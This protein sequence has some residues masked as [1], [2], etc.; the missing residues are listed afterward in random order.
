[1]KI[2]FWT[3]NM[4]Y[5]NLNLLEKLKIIKSL[6][7]FDWVEIACTWHWYKFSNEELDLLKTFNTNTFHL[8]FFDKNEIDFCNYII[9]NI[10]NF[11]HFV[12]HPD[13]IILNDIPQYLHKYISIENMD[14][15]KKSHKFPNEIENLFKNY[16]NLNFTFD[17]NHCDE[18]K[19]KRQE[20]LDIKIPK[21][22]HFSTVNN[23][24]YPNN[25][26]IETPH[27]LAHLDKN[28]KINENYS[29]KKIIVTLEWVVVKNDIESIKKEYHF[30]KKILQNNI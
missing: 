30:C 11:S 28:F 17:I 7:L 18:N 20:F 19:L 14:T 27:A 15:A 21:Q 4:Y 2:L 3:G 24:F 12:L 1:M 5:W 9:E 29:N 23:N 22:L 25:P 6:N 26:E 13:N 16:P 8:Y 10:P